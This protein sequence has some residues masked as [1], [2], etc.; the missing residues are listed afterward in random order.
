MTTAYPPS[1]E[2]LGIIIR[3]VQVNELMI[4]LLF[5]NPKSNKTIS[6]L[7]NQCDKTRNFDEGFVQRIMI[8]RGHPEGWLLSYLMICVVTLSL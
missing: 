1:S 5:K 4:Y 8:S 3:Y 2:T 6:T 7:S